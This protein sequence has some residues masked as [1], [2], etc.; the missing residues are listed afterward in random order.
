MKLK[1][2]SKIGAILLATGLVCGLVGCGHT[3]KYSSEWKSDAESH[4]LPATC[5][6]KDEFTGKEAHSF[7]NGECTVCG[8][9]DPAF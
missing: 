6:H 4:W 9:P 7:E 5:E 1:I 3:H 2:L 8:S